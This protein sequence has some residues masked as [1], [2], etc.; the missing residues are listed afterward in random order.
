VPP[1]QQ[2]P[3]HGDAPEQLVVH[4]PLLQASFSGQSPAVWH[5]THAPP[6]QCCDPAHTAHAPLLPHALFAVPGWHIVPS[7]QPPL[8]TRAPVQL[9]PHTPVTVLHACP[10]G[11]LAGDTHGGGESMGGGAS[12]GSWA[13]TGD[14][15]SV[16]GGA[17]TGGLVSAGT[18]VLSAEPSRGGFES[19][20]VVSGAASRNTSSA[21]SEERD[22]SAEARV[23]SPGTHAGASTAE[24]ATLNRTPRARSKRAPPSVLG[25]GAGYRCTG[26]DYRALRTTGS[27]AQV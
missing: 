14:R 6:A 15:T 17:S 10:R 2:P 5:C 27:G 23:S 8:Q 7:Q 11:Q 26:Q 21:P 20:A 18:E 9:G 22:A 25:C 24:S 13:S 19:A 1:K 16:G 12:I 3:L 4:E